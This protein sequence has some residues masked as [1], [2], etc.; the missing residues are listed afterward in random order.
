M[1][2][3]DR[4]AELGGASLGEPLRAEQ[5]PSPV[6]EG[7]LGQLLL[8]KNGF[9][10]FESSLHIFP[11]G[12]GQTPMSL[13]A[14]NDPGLWRSA[15]PD[16]PQS[17][18]FFAEDAFGSQ[19]GI[20]GHCVV[21]FDPETGELASLAADLDDWA[22]TVLKEYEVLTGYPLGH[23]WQEEHGALPEGQRLVPKVPF[24]LGGEFSVD[25]LHALDAVQGMKLRGSI[26]SQIRDLPDGTEVVFS[27]E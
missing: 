21:S 18:V 22:A 20:Q 15:Y 11:C 9:L 23:A 25:N 19:F 14:W 4:L 8:Q 2:S 16:L 12:T 10:A 6:L 7:G 27:V 17:L 5:I 26:A 3:L 1:N 13:E 24:V